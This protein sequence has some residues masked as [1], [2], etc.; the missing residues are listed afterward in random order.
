MTDE[1]E[2]ILLARAKMSK[3]HLSNDVNDSLYQSD[4]IRSL[5]P[6]RSLVELENF[7]NTT[8]AEHQVQQVYLNMKRTATVFFFLIIS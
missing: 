1:E 7:A 6:R 8:A 3:L 5:Y 4:S 2:L